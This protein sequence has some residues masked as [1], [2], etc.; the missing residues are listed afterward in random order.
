MPA[1]ARILLTGFEPFLEHRE[2]PSALVGEALDGTLVA[3]ARIHAATL[4]VA[5][6]RA[7]AALFDAMDRVRPD[8]VVLCGL[9]FDANAI[10]LERVALNLDDTRH[11]DN[12]G[13]VRQGRPILPG[14]PVG[15]WS[16]LPV[17]A[18]RA[19]LEAAGVPVVTSRDAGGYLCNHVFFQARQRIAGA[20]R[21]IPCGFVHLPPL[22]DQVAGRAGRAGM[23]LLDQVR[24]VTLLI[25]TV[26]AAAS[27]SATA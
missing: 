23:T 14:G 21:D 13:T 24:A 2:N 6:D 19:G 17:D 20:G 7:P 27:G 22:P 15:H 10:R 1:I 11:A 8:A 4:P 3:G 25:E 12:D 18:I 16:T 9:A 26:V 5:Y